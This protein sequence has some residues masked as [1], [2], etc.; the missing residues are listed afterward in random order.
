VRAAGTLHERD[1]SGVQISALAER[2]NG[3]HN[4]RA[5]FPDHSR[6]WPV[7]RP[8]LAVPAWRVNSRRRSRML[9]RTIT[10]GSGADAC[11]TTPTRFREAA[12]ASAGSASRTLTRPRVGLRKPARIRHGVILAGRL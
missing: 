10:T 12:P 11:S 4:V 6:R 5:V 7:R 1:P 9:S 8:R 2:G 3:G